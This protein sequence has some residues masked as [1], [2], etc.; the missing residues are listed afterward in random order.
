M[1]VRR[2]LSLMTLAVAASCDRGAKA[3]PDSI[4]QTGVA[5]DDVPW[6]S[7]LGPVFAVP[8]DSDNTAVVLFPSDTA[9]RADVSLLRTAG[10]SSR[11]ARI[12]ATETDSAI[13]GEASPARLSASGPA[14]WT[15]A[16]VPSVTAVRLDSIESLSPADSTTLATEVARLASAVPSDKDS[17]FNGLPFAVLAAHRFSVDS[18][19]VIIGRV[20]RRIPQ[21]ATPLEERT[22]VVGERNR[23]GAFA[24]KYSL[25]S[26]GSEETVEH[27]LLLATVRAAGKIFVVLESER[28]SAARYEIVERIAGPWQRRWSRTLS[29]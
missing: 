27:F 21:E 6:V 20:A 14:G 3:P 11:P 7:E 12:T 8:G 4:A 28:E 25:R 22:L 9:A 18:S 17:R 1:R 26:A 16:F 24:L 5:E 23:S 29:C 15:L 13:C 19:T 2:F 10:D